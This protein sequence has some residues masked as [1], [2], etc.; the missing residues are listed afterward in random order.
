MQ[1]GELQGQTAL[2]A[3]QRGGGG[4]WGGR[5]T[6]SATPQLELDAVMSHS[7]SAAAR[8]SHDNQITP[9]LFTKCK[10]VNAPRDHDLDQR[11]K[12]WFPDPTLTTPQPTPPTLGYLFI[13]LPSM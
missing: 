1:D 11:I 2:Y 8:R 5:F 9:T 13:S 4:G 7:T 6:V 10:D 3:A 12:L